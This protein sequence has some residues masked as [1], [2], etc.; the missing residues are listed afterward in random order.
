MFG[1]ICG[2]VW[3]SEGNFSFNSCL[4]GGP[5]RWLQGDKPR[6]EIRKVDL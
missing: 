4:V 5:S 2:R 6:K 1:V 3:G